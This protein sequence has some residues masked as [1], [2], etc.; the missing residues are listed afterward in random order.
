MEKDAFF[1]FESN[2]YVN[3][4][5]GFGSVAHGIAIEAMLQKV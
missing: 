5:L 2:E 3:T 4:G 1:G